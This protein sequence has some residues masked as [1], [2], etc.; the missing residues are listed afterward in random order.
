MREQ[1]QARLETLRK[2]FE[3]GQAKLRELEAQQGLLRDTLLRISGAI[4]ILEEMLAEEK[5]EVAGDSRPV[6][7]HRA[8][9]AGDRDPR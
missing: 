2:D 1:M 4:Q 3:T 7:L 9:A 6:V 8:A 5:Q